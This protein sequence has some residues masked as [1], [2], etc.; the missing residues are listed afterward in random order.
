M[1]TTDTVTPTATTTTTTT[2]AEATLSAERQ[3]PWARV[4]RLVDESGERLELNTTGDVLEATG[5]DFTVSKRP[6]RRRALDGTWLESKRVSVVRDDTEEE[7]DVVSQDYGVFQFTE[8]F[9]FLNHIPG[10]EFVAA[11]PLKDSRQAFMVVRLPDLAGFD[12]AGSDRHELNVVIRTSHDRSRAVEVFTMPLRVT[13][14]NQLPLRPLGQGI[15][16]RWSVNHIGDVSGKMHD[17]E[18]LVERVRDYVADFRETAERLVTI[19]LGTEQA[20]TTLRRVLRE[21]P[22]KEETIETIMS[23]WA[24]ADTVGFHGTG[25]GLVNAVSDYYE[26][27]RRGGTDQSRLLGALEGQTRSILDRTVPFILGRFGK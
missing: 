21:A 13:C 2:T 23:L 3:S 7:V 19:E 12:I 25:W 26:H 14:V 27:G 20:A 8:A 22:K 1:T 15:T 10:R 5:L 11:G 17:A 6:M 18:T 16:N 4:N 9:E 24:N